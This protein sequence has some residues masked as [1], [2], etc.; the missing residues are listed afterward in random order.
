MQPRREE[1]G[2]RFVPGLEVWP[3][4]W[5]ARLAALHPGAWLWL[6]V[7][8]APRHPPQHNGVR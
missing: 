8:S 5:P 2:G 6:C 1:A 3:A 4:V 7:A